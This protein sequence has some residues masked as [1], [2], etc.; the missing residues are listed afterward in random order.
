MSSG[1]KRTFLEQT[2][3]KLVL[4]PT[5]YGHFYVEHNRGHHRD[6]ATRHRSG[7]VPDGRI[8]LCVCLPRAAGRLEAC[9]GA[10]TAAPGRRAVAMA[11]RGAAAA[12][13]DRGAVDGAG[14]LAGAARP[15][16]H[17]RDV[18]LGQ[19]PAD[20]GELHRTLRAAARVGENG[21][22]E[23]CRP[24]HSWNSN[25]MVTNWMLFHLQ[26][27]SDHH[28]H[29]SRRYQALRNFA[30]VPTL[31][32]GYFGMFLLA[33]FPPLFFRVMNPRL[34]AA[35]GS[36]PERINFQPSKRER[37]IQQYAL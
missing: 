27:H 22:P 15:A 11:Q 6:V 10:G 1:H 9:V 3:A 32:N 33:Y 28:A 5:A 30:D 24:H 2:L 12:G 7:F 35:V 21:K 19:F 36:D 18:V 17:D 13:A 29:A 20:A 25:H 8:D 26:R 37:L 23:A 4:A 14:D 16:F 34:L 31:P